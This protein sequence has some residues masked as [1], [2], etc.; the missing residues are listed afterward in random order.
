M[1]S[2]THERQIAHHVE[3]IR[4]LEATNKALLEA[5]EGLWAAVYDAR[6]VEKYP[7]VTAAITS[8]MDEAERISQQVRN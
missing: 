7:W 4:E 3:E 1:S 8:A 5:L 6:E 2:H